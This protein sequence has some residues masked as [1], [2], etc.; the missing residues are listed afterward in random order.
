MARARLLKPGFFTN[1]ELVE[2][3]FGTRLLFQGLWILADREGRL[4]DRPKRIKMAV[5]PADDIDVDACLT[6]LAEHGLIRRYTVGTGRYIHVVNFLKHQTP[7]HREPES[8][9]PSPPG[10]DADGMPVIPVQVH[11]EPAAGPSPALGEPTASRAVTSYQYTETVTGSG[12]EHTP[13]APARLREEPADGF[14]EFYAEYPRHDDR[15]EAVKAW[16][17]L[18]ETQR[19]MARDALTGWKAC[20]Q[21]QTA[22]FVPMA[23]TYLNQRRF[24]NAPVTDASALV[25]N[26]ARAPNGRP[27][28]RSLDAIKRDESRQGMAAWNAMMDEEEQDHG[29]HHLQSGN[30][31]AQ[32]RIQPGAGRP[33]AGYILGPGEEP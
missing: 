13:P 10:S 15:R 32:R 8:V 16:N 20:E 21:W 17:R 26:G 1:E 6:L 3:D 33:A 22:R 23:S 18:T 2:V 5:F 25:A 11:D 29:T 4:E 30:G 12:E 19:R 31:T 28:I 9:I 7:H 27:E 24:E 14:A